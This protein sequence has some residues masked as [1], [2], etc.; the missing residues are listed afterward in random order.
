MGK[1]EL[2]FPFLSRIFRSEQFI[3]L[4][5]AAFVGVCAAYGAIAFRAL[6]LG[7]GWLFFGPAYG[8]LGAVAEMAWY[9]RLFLPVLGGLILAPIIVRWA[10]EAKGSGIP[11]VIEAT[12]LRGGAVRR[13]VVPL[14]ALAAAICIGSGGS[15]GREGPIVHIGAAIGSWI[16]QAM[17]LTVKQMRTLVGCGVAGG[18][19]ATFN[20]PFAGA[21]FAVEAVLGDFG[22]AKISPI[23]IASVVATVVSR[24]FTEEFPQIEVQGFTEAIGIWSVP[25][26]LLVGVACA[27]VGSLFIKCMARGWRMADQWKGSPYLLPAFGGL[28][29]GAIGL[30]LPEVYGVGY[31]TINRVLSSTPGVGFLLLVL[32]AKLV[33]T[34]ATLTSGGSGGIFAPSLFLGALTGGLVGVA[35]QWVAPEVAEA[36]RTFA[37]VG[38]GA[39]VAATTRAPIS[40]VLIIFEMTKDYNTIVPLMAACIPSVLISAVLHK[41]SIYIAKLTHRGIDLGPK[42]ELNLLRGLPVRDVMHTRVD[43]IAPGTPMPQLIEKFLE[44][45]YSIL[46]VVDDARRLVG[47][48]EARNFQLALVEQDTLM[49]LI[50]A[51]DLAVPVQCPVHPDDDLSL[52]S[53]MLDDVTFEVFPVVDKRTGVLLGDL[54]R[55]DVMEAYHRELARRDAVTTAVDAI[56]ASDR[57]DMVDIGNGYVIMEYEAPTHWSGKTLAE[58]DLRKRVGGQ[59]LLIKRGTEQVFPGPRTDVRIGDVLLLTGPAKRLEKG[60]ARI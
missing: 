31:E 29:V 7:S 55:G 50:V 25:P 42:G 46:W 60:L 8:D 27:V 51:Q 47:V 54:M 4:I 56:S 48:V 57:L 33:A 16:A 36:P 9:R 10:P 49:E 38:M 34:T 19:A 21:L 13:R 26:Y 23:V 18:I 12:A 41:D 5:S 52:V 30:F 6:I 39:M 32:V 45:K 53:T 35:M 58:L 14:K 1:L 11:E 40:A 44:T 17:H 22:T 15:A 28:I 24:Q 2:W 59:V 20:T 43:S 3:I 37:L